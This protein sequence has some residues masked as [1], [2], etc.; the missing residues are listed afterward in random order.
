MIG[1]VLD[2]LRHTV[3]KVNAR[4]ELDKLVKDVNELGKDVQMLSHQL[5]SLKLDYLGLAGA[6]K[7]LCREL[8]ER[9]QVQIRFTDTGIPRSLPPDLA[10]ALFRIT[11]EALHNALKYS[12]AREFNVSLNRIDNDIELA[13]RDK[14]VGFDVDTAMKGHGLGLISMRERIL[15]LKGVLTIRSQPMQ[16]TEVRVRAPLTST[17]SN[18]ARPRALVG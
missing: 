2:Q 12:G 10:L 13:V 16:E 7:S 6:M 3:S 18:D 9:Q 1:V 8:S 15:A 5:H 11:Q 17:D 4:E 14:G